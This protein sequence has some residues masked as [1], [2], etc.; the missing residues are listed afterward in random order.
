MGKVP[1]LLSCDP[2]SSFS[3]MPRHRVI[4]ASQSPQQDAH[5]IDRQVFLNEV[6]QSVI[7]D[8]IETRIGRSQLLDLLDLVEDG[9][10]QRCGKILCSIRLRWRMIQC[11]PSSLRR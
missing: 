6:R 7:R 1:Q 10:V 3:T 8:A 4:N 5:R 11:N 9:W 2:F